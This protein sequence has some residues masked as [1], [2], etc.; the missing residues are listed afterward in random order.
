ME[1]KPLA[2]TGVTCPTEVDGDS[3]C[4]SLEDEDDVKAEEAW[5]EVLR[6]ESPLTCCEVAERGAGG[7]GT[8]G[9]GVGGGSLIAGREPLGYPMAL[10]G[11]R[12][13][14]GG[15]ALRAI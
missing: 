1:P 6:F 5:E 9:G 7:G 8:E 4:D 11:E 10:S 3:G 15:E 13:P 14:L 2:P 12:A